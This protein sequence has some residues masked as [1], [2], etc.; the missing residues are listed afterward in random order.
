[1][2]LM[3]DI[4]HGL[5]YIYIYIYKIYL[6]AYRTLWKLTLCT[7]WSKYRCNCWQVSCV[8]QFSENL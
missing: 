3:L 8:K 1:L 6:E 4:S 7:S 5:I 2:S